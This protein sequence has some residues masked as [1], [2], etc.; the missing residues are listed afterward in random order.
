MVLLAFMVRKIFTKNCS[1]VHYLLRDF[2]FLASLGTQSSLENSETSKIIFFE[3]IQMLFHICPI[4]KSEPERQKSFIQLKALKTNS[5][6]S[7]SALSFFNLH[8]NYPNERTWSLKNF[9]TS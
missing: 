3:F 8:H 2:S 4:L 6:I 5:A 7:P 1:G 9:R